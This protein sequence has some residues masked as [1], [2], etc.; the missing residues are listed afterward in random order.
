[1]DRT[2]Q[3]TE[4]HVIFR[5]SFRRF[6]NKEVGD[7]YPHWEAEGICPR[8]IWKKFGENGYLLPWAEEK[9][10]GAGADWIYSVIV[11]EEMA[12]FGASGL[13]VPLHNDVVAPYIYT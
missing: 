9:Y 8:E 4:G 12:R 1:M 10:G 11:I 7:Q 13:F 2:V 3:F 6:L 5:E